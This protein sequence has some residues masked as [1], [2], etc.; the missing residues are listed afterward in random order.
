MT[1]AAPG[2]LSRPLVRVLCAIAGT[3]VLAVTVWAA[4]A[5]AVLAGL[6]ASVH[7]LPALAGLEVVMLACSTLAL[8]ALYGAG[9]ARVSGRQWLRAGAAG[10]AVGLV[11][12]MGRGSGEAARA[13]LLGRSVGGA[14]AAVAAV[15]MQGVVLL[16][17][18][19]SIL[20]PLVAT[21]ILLG[22]GAT[23]GLMLAN[24]LIAAVVGASILVLRERTRPGRLLGGV[25]KRLQRFG[26]A[27]DAADGAS[28]A[29]LLRS[30]AWETAGRVAQ[31]A[32]CAV[33]LAA[34]GHP[35][36][37]VRVL[38]ARGL[39]MVGSALGDII[40]GQLGATE[41]A[42]VVGADALGLT[43]A[44]AASLALVIHGAQIV[45][46]L[47][48]TAVSFAVP[49]RRDVTPGGVKVAP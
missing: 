47:V 18:T 13:V 3:A 26:H 9:A 48:C 5:R 20:P 16:S 27:F 1:T 10:Y 2:L 46:G 12:P 42:L 44:S 7:A 4:G 24:G 36:G 17:T 38:V 15:Q 35:S 30:L 23:A 32:Q 28:P 6:G 14:R 11:L 39:S 22:A 8:R 33:A 45:L 43:A 37:L 40:P 34:I 21:L 29:D 49:D 41:A 19:V 31:V 25:V